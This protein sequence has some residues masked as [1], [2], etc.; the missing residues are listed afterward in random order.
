[1]TA[2]RNTRTTTTPGTST[3]GTGRAMLV[4]A[5]CLLAVNGFAVW[6]SVFHED[7]YS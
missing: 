4:Y 3:E 2:S 1:L 6:Y 7:K 5:A